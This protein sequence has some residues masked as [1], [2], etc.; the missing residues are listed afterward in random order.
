M[1]STPKVSD[2]SL[3]LGVLFV[4]FQGTYIHSWRS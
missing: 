2:E 3:T 1:K 4:H